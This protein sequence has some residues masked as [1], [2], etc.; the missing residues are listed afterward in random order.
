MLPTP[1]AVRHRLEIDIFNVPMRPCRGPQELIYEF[2][3]DGK[4]RFDW[5][6]M[7]QNWIFVQNPEILTYCEPCPLN[8]FQGVEGCKGEIDHLEPFLR[9]VAELA[10][11]SPLNDLS[12]DG[13]PVPADLTRAMRA[14]LPK[15]EQA[16]KGRRW[17]VA[18]V[19]REGLALRE[20]FPDGTN[21]QLF[22]A[23]NGEGPPA[24]IAVNEGYQIYLSQHGLIVK[25][26]YE[27]PVPTAFRRLVRN[28]RTV[29]GEALNGE[30]IGFQMSMARY[31]AWDP[32]D[33]NVDG[34]LEL[35]T[36]PADE[37]FREVLD[38]LDVF[39]TLAS[40]AETG[41]VV[42]PL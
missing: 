12:L 4:P 25:A 2:Y 31:P 33:P 37:V 6:R 28:G 26:T 42:T 39:S 9:A 7:R 23:W 13:S 20:Y 38:L 30:S 24:L 1:S 18:Q 5:D 16:L 22:Y 34:S 8:V 19:F 32:Q 21:R 11:D 35:T 41:L 3:H 40:H 17:P 29:S 10:P 15:V 36:F 14:D 27:D